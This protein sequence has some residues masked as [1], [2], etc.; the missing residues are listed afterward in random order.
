MTS[1]ESYYWVWSQMPQLS[2]YDHPPFVAWLYW[3]GSQIDFYGSMVRWPGVLMLHLSLGIWLK[4][5]KPYLSDSQRLWWLGLAL[6]S[7]LLGGCG[8]IVTPDVPLLFFYAL[9][10]W[11]FF[12]Y[13]KGPSISLALGLG[14]SL[15]FG[16]TSK[17]M[18][19]LFVFSVLPLM[20]FQREVRRP[21]LKGMFW[22]F[23]GGVIGS[24]PV[25]LWNIQ[26]DFASIRFQTSH[27]LG[28]TNWKIEW[29]IHYLGGQLGILFPV[30]VYWAYRARRRMPLSFQ[31][32]AWVPLGFFFL[33]SFRKYVEANWPIVAYPAMF[34]LAVSALPESR[35]GLKVTLGFWALFLA[36]VGLIVFSEPKWSK[37]FKFREFHQYDALVEAGRNYQPLF[38]RSYQIASK[39][40]FELKRP[41]Y[42][43]KGV[44]RKDFFDFIEQSEPTGDRFYMVSE[45]GDRFSLLYQSRGYEIVERIPVDEMHDIWRVEKKPGLGSKSDK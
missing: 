9:S 23:I 18:I 20:I 34:A 36:T 28:E 16:F 13:L 37:N 41:V 19:V 12:R 7:P 17:Y 26:N 27:G 11:I 5:L 4:T 10:T 25:W 3:L 21:L 45:K 44:N 30:I 22:V 33:T 14:L 1:D 40:Y 24:L 39:L 31:F 6:L 35:K 8:V 43:L 32:F 2:Y 15:G 38:A 42:K 29:P